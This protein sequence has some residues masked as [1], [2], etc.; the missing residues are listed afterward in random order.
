MPATNTHNTHNS[1]TRVLLRNHGKGLLR[2]A[3]LLHLPFLRVSPVEHA[4]HALCAPALKY[5][6]GGSPRAEPAF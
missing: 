5:E 1:H 3:A 2:F 6:H 4:H